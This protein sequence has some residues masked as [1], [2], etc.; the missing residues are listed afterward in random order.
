[1]ALRDPKIARPHLYRL[2][3]ERIFFGHGLWCLFASFVNPIVSILKTLS[4]FLPLL[5]E[6]AGARTVV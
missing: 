4:T 2:P 1:M 6:K 5:E 3:R